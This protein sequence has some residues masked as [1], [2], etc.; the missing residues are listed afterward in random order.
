MG[1][2]TE[3][4]TWSCGV[5]LL[6]VATAAGCDQASPVRLLE[7]AQPSRVCASE[8]T[9]DGVRELLVRDLGQRLYNGEYWLPGASRDASVAFA[10]GLDKRALIQ[11]EAITYEGRD[12]ETGRIR[13]RASL[14][15]TGGSRTWVVYEPVRFS[16]QPSA[17]GETFVFSV[18]DVT[19]PLGA[20]FRATERDYQVRRSSE[21]PT[22]S[23]SPS[24]ASE[25]SNTDG[26]APL[27]PGGSGVSTSDAFSFVTTDARWRD[28][29]GRCGQ[30]YRTGSGD[31]EACRER[32]RIGAEFEAAGYCYTRISN[33]PH[34]E[35]SWRHCATGLPP[36]CSVAYRPPPPLSVSA[37]APATAPM[38]DQQPEPTLPANALPPPPAPP[39][40]NPV[41]LTMPNGEDLASL[42][43]ARAASLA[44][45]GRSVVQCG[46]TRIGTL[47]NCFIYSESPTAFGFG[48]AAL[49]A[50][51]LYRA[52]PQDGNGRSTAGAS[53]RVAMNWQAASEPKD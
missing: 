31:R 19:A 43:P 52:A 24:P 4:Q 50:A 3:L 18:E 39:I 45:G 10:N 21:R 25:E 29:S 14:Q 12:E 13:C 23:P 53:V 22:S 37:V 33:N 9:L 8:D 35:C 28:A 49:E 32:E 11:F 36:A 5:V 48:Q 47:T 30:S 20:L 7:S 6:A 41:W 42:Y 2:R 26:P 38:G 16:R 40:S 1:R 51:R 27:S 34:A 44:V 15:A 46:I 17:N